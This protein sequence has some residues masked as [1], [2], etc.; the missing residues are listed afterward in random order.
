MTS[1]GFFFAG[2]ICAILVAAFYALWVIE[3]MPRV[4]AKCARLS[5]DMPVFDALF[6]WHPWFAWRPVKTEDERL[7]WMIW[8]ERRYPDKH[9][10]FDW[11]ALEDLAPKP[12]FRQT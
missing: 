12:E 6:E 4:D 2:V 11:W 7:A 3:I 9:K 8:V 10:H 1:D 5:Q